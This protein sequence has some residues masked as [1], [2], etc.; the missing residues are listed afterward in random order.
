[1]LE[2]FATIRLGQDD[3]GTSEPGDVDIVNRRFPNLEEDEDEEEGDYTPT[4]RYQYSR[5]HKLA[6]IDYFQ[7][8]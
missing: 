2:L 5:E 3:E 4:K 1:V 8:T 6:T 7:T